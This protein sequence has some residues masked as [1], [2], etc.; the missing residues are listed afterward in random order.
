MF[1]IKRLKKDDNFINE[2]ILM[3]ILAY[4]YYIFQINLVM[5]TLPKIKAFKIL[6]TKMHLWN[7]V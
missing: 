5:L 2:L 3:K 7:V 4:F 1:R 6:K